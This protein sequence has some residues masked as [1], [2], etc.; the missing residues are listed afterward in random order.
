MKAPRGIEDGGKSTLKLSSG[1][2]IHL[3]YM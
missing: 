3:K 2:D 1:H